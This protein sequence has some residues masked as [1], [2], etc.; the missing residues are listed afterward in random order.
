M[1]SQLPHLPN[2]GSSNY[3]QKSTLDRRLLTLTEL[4][5]KA[6]FFVPRSDET[7][8]NAAANNKSGAWN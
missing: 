3:E 7:F 6:A 5:A 1:G 2:D 4:A 8:R